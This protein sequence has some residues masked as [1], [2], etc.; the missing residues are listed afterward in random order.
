MC[1]TGISITDARMVFA[2]L[3]IHPPSAHMFQDYA[4]STAQEWEEVNE[5]TMAENRQIFKSVS[6]PV[7]GVVG[8]DTCFNNPPKGQ[9]FYQPGSQSHTP[10]VCALTG[11]VLAFVSH[12][13]LCSYNHVGPCGPSCT[14]TWPKHLAMGG[15]ERAAAIANM[16]KLRQAGIDVT[17]CLMDGTARALTGRKLSHIKIKRTYP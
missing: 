4:N 7:K 11:L 15:T 10:M 14:I 5:D 16:R 2:A 13:K 12:N 6:G 17:A 9:G 3:D 1:K 8:Q